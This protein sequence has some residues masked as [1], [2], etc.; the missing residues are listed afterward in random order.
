MKD[1]ICALEISHKYLKIVFGYTQDNQVMATFVKKIPL[2]HA[3]ESGAIRDREAIIKELSRNNPVMDDTLHFSHLINNAILVLPPY[4]LEIYET[5]Q[6]TSVISPEKVVGDLDIKN[7]YNIIRNKKL[8]I[9]NELIDIIPDSFMLDNGNRYALPPVGKESSAITVHAKVHTLPKRINEE[10]TSCLVDSNIKVARRVVSPFAVSELLATYNDVPA[11]YFLVD[12]GACSTTISLVDN[13][14]IFATRS[15]SWGGDN[16]TNSIVT[17]FNISEE[18]AERIKILFGLDKREMKFDYPIAK[19]SSPLGD[20]NCTVS[21]L[22]QIIE[23]ELFSFINMLNLGIEQLV[24]AYNIDEPNTMPIIFIGGASQLKGTKAF[25]D[26]N[27]NNKNLIFLRNKTIG[28]R[29]PSLT[30]LLGSIL[31]NKKFPV[32]RNEN[33]PQVQVTRDSK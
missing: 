24:N 11:T 23:K 15:F 27:L 17:S 3:L 31:V 14:Q 30:A 20:V 1:S 33:N 22:N 9:D 10:H 4:G 25:F 19:A 5:T 8:P 12:M 26:K 7:I 32:N 18:E 6:F 29:D 2:G 13:H 28:A 16:I 21:Q